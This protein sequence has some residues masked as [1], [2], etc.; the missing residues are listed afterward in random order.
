MIEREEDRNVVVKTCINYLISTEQ[1]K[2]TYSHGNVHD[3]VPLWA[4]YGKHCMDPSCQPGLDRRKRVFLLH[5]L[6]QDDCRPVVQCQMHFGHYS[7]WRCSN[8][9]IW[10]WLSRCG[11]CV[12][13]RYYR[14]FEVVRFDGQRWAYSSN[15]CSCQVG[16]TVRQTL[17]VVHE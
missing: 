13:M 5:C 17:D 9:D 10:V 1:K 15:S 6:V 11:R 12:E 16:C 2:L 7:S 14:I 8:Y 4:L 3:T